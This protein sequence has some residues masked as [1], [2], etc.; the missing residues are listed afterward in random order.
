MGN[1]VQHREDIP[2]PEVVSFRLKQLSYDLELQLAELKTDIDLALRQK[3]VMAFK[4]ISTTVENLIMLRSSID[5]LRS[6]G[7]YYENA[8]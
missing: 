1:I 7:G 2:M 3:T 4:R 6:V 8:Y 5:A